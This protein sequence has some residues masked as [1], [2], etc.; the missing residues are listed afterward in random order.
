MQSLQKK[1]RV[2]MK[3]I[4]KMVPGL[5]MALVIAAAAKGL[6]YLEGLEGLH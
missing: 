1:R 6:E 5:A 3:M 2:L 4:W